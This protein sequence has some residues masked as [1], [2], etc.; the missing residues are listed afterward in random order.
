M[1]SLDFGGGDGSK[2][3]I[4][5]WYERLEAAIQAALDR[6][7]EHDWTT[8]WYSSKKELATGRITKQGNVILCEATQ[9]DDFDTDGQG[10]VEIPYTTDIEAVRE[11]MDRAHALAEQDRD[12]KAVYMGFSILDAKGFRID[13]YLV[14]TATG[15]YMESPPGDNYDSWGWQ[16]DAEIPKDV[17]DALSAWADDVANHDE[18]QFSY[19]G[20]TIRRWR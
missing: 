8:G 7:V 3:G 9:D 17:M 15:H 5:D 11:A 6:G 4:S 2:W 12:E 20:F 14:P 10:S 1:T 18:D 19:G 13:T 16:G